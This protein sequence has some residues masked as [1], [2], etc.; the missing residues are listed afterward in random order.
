MA[1]QHGNECFCSREEDL[2]YLRHGIG[3]CDMACTGDNVRRLARAGTTLGELVAHACT[4]N[5]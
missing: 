3:K 5:T 1:T 2:E 4:E